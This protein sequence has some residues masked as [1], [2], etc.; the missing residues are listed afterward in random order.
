MP[1]STEPPQGKSPD[2]AQTHEHGTSPTSPPKP[3]AK[4]I[5]LAV[6]GMSPAII[7]ETV[8]K[9]AHPDAGKEKIIPNEVVVITTTRGLLDINRDLKNLDEEGK[10]KPRPG[11]GGKSVWQAL[12]EAVLGTAAGSDQRLQLSAPLIIE[13]PN[14]ETGVK[15][16][17][18]DIRTEAD[19]IAAV[20]FILEKA[21]RGL[22]GNPE[23][24]VIASIA[25][26]RKTM[27]SLLYAC[28]SLLARE[29]DRVTHVLVRGASGEKFD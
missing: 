5:L 10:F 28:M 29:T 11:W 9:L 22:V 23:V 16:P 8:W 15:T 17:A 24:R 1:S 3:L 25:G 13:L 18:E 2:R 21:V 19:N 27:G 4:T 26:G 6:S 20:D 14:Q 7:T 12:R